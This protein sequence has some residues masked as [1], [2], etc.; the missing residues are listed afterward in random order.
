MH[1]V[2]VLENWTH[3][4]DYAIFKKIEE[5]CWIYWNIGKRYFNTLTVLQFWQV[6]LQKKKYDILRKL[7]IKTPAKAP[8]VVCWF[9]SKPWADRSQNIRRG[10]DVGS[11]KPQ[12][13]RTAT[14]F[15]GCATFTHMKDIRS[16]FATKILNCLLATNINI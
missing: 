2:L 14:E 7:S 5:K 13:G 10:L 16:R 12:N 6:H 4:C 9:R 3:F 15:P 11:H 8:C 1:V